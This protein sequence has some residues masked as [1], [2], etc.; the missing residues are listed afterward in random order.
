MRN[1]A[2]VK[3]NS[4]VV[5]FEHGVRVMKLRAELAEWRARLR[6]AFE[7]DW[8]LAARRIIEYEIARRRKEINEC[9][10]KWL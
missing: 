6:L 7:C 3:E 2:S 4:N 9:G 1:N 5:L 10:R 8:S